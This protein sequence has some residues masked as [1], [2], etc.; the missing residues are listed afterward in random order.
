MAKSKITEVIENAIPTDAPFDT[1]ET[2]STATTTTDETLN[3]TDTTAESKSR[4]EAFAK[5]SR[6]A[7]LSGV[8]HQTT[9][10]IKRKIGEF[11]DD[12]ELQDEGQNQELLGKVHRLVGS[13]RAIRESAIATANAKR[14]ETQT[15]FIKHGGRM[16][17]VAGDLAEDLKKTLFR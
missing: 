15:I 16:L 12:N 10:K 9:G 6:A 17:D 14:K 8:F 4:L 3:T 2:N 7:K 1:V 11:R 13:I 5:T